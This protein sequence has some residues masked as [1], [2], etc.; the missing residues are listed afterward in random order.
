MPATTTGTARPVAERGRCR[1]ATRDLARPMVTA[2]GTVG[3]SRV[4]FWV[5]VDLGTETL[6]RVV[7]KLP[8]Y[9]QAARAGRATRSCSGWAAPRARR[10][11][12]RCLARTGVPAGLAVATATVDAANPAG[13]VWHV[14]GQPRRSAW[15]TFRR[16]PDTGLG[17]GAEAVF[18]GRVERGGAGAVALLVVVPAA[19][20]V[21]GV[22]RL[23][24]RRRWRRRVSVTCAVR[25]APPRASPV[26]K[27]RNAALIIAVGPRCGCRYG[28]G[29]SRSRPRCRSRT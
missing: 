6:A 18:R 10:T 5:E 24:R 27:P 22:R 26:S 16:P 7:G 11:C 20:A 29:S 15:P 3:R 2:C 17:D 4:P 25:P 12:T 23:V 28:A 21:R 1:S 13:S 9:A 19:A 8:G 14:P